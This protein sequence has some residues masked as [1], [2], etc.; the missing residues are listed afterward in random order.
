MEDCLAVEQTLLQ[1]EKAQYE[2][3]AAEVTNQM[4]ADGM[5]SF[6]FLISS[7]SSLLT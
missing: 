4:Y 6:Y 1:K 2:R 3:H 7:L 5:V